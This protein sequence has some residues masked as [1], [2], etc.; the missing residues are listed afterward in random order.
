MS[1]IHKA[2]PGRPAGA[3]GK[4]MILRM[5]ESHRP[6]REWAFS[7]MEWKP[8]MRILDVG[9]GGGATI[10]DML[11]LTRAGIVDG[12]DY[13]ADCVETARFVNLD[14]IGRRCTIKQGDVARLPFT[15][16]QYDLVTAVETLY[17]WPDPNAGLKEIHRVLKKGGMIA[18]LLETG[19]PDGMDWEEV[20]FEMTVYRPDEI[21]EML[22]ECG[23]TDILADTKDNGYLLVRGRKG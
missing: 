2:D 21:R 17:F 20:N 23:F 6:L 11:A 8:I 14:E 19:D 12:V 4:K 18:I 13:S 1:D 5:N 22:T 9:C 7:M 15:N 16:E 3:D 10:K